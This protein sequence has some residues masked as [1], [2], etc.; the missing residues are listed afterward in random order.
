MSLAKTYTRAQVGVNAPLVTV[1]VHLSNGLP[2]FNIVGLP[3][4][5]VKES[6][7]RVR[8]ALTHC[9]FLFPEQR[10]TVNLA[11]ADLPKQGGRYD[12]AIAIGILLASGQLQNTQIHEY[13]FYGELALTGEVREVTAVIPALIAAAKA[14]RCCFIPLSNK[15]MASLVTYG[16]RKSA[17]SLRDVWMDL[18]GQQ[19]LSFDEAMTCPDEDQFNMSIDMNEV[20]GQVVA[21]RVLEIAAAGAHNVLFLG[22]PGTGKSMLAQRMSTIMPPMQIEQALETASV[23]SL[24][25][26]SI[27]P[28]KWRQ[29]PFRSPH[30]TCSAVALVGGSSTPKPGE[31]SLAHNGIL[32]LDELP[33]YERKVLD[34]LR[35][36]METGMVNISRAAQQVDFPARFQLIAALNPSPTGCHHD[37][38]ST[39]DQVLRYL[40]KISGPFVDRIDLQIELPRLSTSELQSKGE[41]EDSACIRARVVRARSAA[42]E[43]QGKEN[44]MLSTKELEK[45][46]ALSDRVSEYLAKAT[47]KLQLSPRSYHRVVKV[48]RTIADLNMHDVI[49]LSDLKEALSYR[50]FERLLSQLT[51]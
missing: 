51:R 20:K 4:A 41:V 26:K 18:G 49:T 25:G 45:Y 16:T 11:P 13:E 29:R 39:P 38:R 28:K 19:T 17:G 1:E 2:A 22:P 3:E 37:K 12:L 9:H 46:C 35:E 40:S 42:I 21:K 34:S 31:I 10:I 5:S 47:E 14:Q 44:A 48:A 27:D 7:E 36:P 15:E 8:C 50:A 6:K 24:I 32:F 33:E 23:Y 43:R 30:H